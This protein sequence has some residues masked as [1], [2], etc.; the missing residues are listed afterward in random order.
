M[1]DLTI[2]LICKVIK[3][4]DIVI[5]KH[6]NPTTMILDSVKLRK[7]RE[8]QK[9]SQAEFADSIDVSQTTICEWEKK[10]TDIKLEYFLKLHEVFGE[11]ILELNKSG[12]YIN[13]NNKNTNKTESDTILGLDIKKDTFQLQKEHIETL[14][15]TNEFMREELRLLISKFSELISLLKPK[16]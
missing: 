7:F 3:L 10:D 15:E 6:L 1:T 14:K 2:N 8:T 16:E 13:I 11:N 12:T 9:M 5:R 4:T